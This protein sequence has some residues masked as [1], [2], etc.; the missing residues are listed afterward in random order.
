M[1]PSQTLDD[2]HLGL[3]D[4]LHGPD[5]DREHNGSDNPQR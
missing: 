2:N 3:P 4:D 5:E 1:K